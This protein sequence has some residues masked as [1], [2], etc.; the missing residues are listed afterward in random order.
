MS[1]YRRKQSPGNTEWFVKDRFGM[2]IHFG[3]YSALARHEWVQCRESI[4]P[5]DYEK[6]MTR[7]DPD[8]FDAKQWAK[9]AKEAGMKYAV[10]TTKHHEGFCLFDSKYTDY[11]ITN[12]P[13]GRDLVKEYVDAFRAEGLKVGFYYSLV[14]WHHP[15]FTIDHIHPMKVLPNAE[16]LNSKRDMTKYAAYMRNQVTELLTNYGK[17]D[18]LWFDFSYKFNPKIPFAAPWMTGKGKNEWES[19]AL[20][21]TARA[22]QPQILINNRSDLEQDLWTPE[23]YQCEQWLTH[24][25]TGELVTWEACHTFSGSWGYYRDE[26]TWKSPEQLIALLVKTVSL[27]GN[28]LMNVGP[29][30]RGYFDHRADQALDVFAKWMR[31]NSRSIYN[32][33]MAEP[34]FIAP[35]GCRLTQSEDGKRLYIHLLEYP[36]NTLQMNCLAGKIAYAQF[37]HD[38]SEVKY[39][40]KVT[41]VGEDAQNSFLLPTVKPDTIVP[42]IEVFLK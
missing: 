6:Y 40:T 11:K 1:S 15:E 18:I 9:K 28:L 5:E 41:I 2:F 32:C 16:E 21:A 31:Y 3:L 35:N 29:T 24:P 19:E 27:G 7:F 8:L 42:V 26:Q 23:Q 37:L 4:Q 20:I 25:E 33:T 12:T 34:E 38:A 13:F 14:D 39:H 30:A 10:L 22:L 17:I 36:F